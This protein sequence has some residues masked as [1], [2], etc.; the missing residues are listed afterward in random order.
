MESDWVSIA[1]ELMDASDAIEVA[2]RRLRNAE[3]AARDAYRGGD[4]L[5]S[6]VVVPVGSRCVMILFDAEDGEMLRFSTD[7]S[8][9]VSK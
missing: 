6:T 8:L 4:Q 7:V 1:S 3:D 2:K 9:G 5:H